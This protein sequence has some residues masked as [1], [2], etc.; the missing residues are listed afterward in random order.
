MS[1]KQQFVQKQAL[2]LKQQLSPK[3]IQQFRLYHLPY[4]EL[5][6]DIKKEAE[7]NV[8]MDITRD[9]QLTPIKGSPRTSD[10]L[11]DVSDFAQDNTQSSL[12]DFLFKQA[13]LVD[14][15]DDTKK[16]LDSLIEAI[17]DSGYIQ[18][19]PSIK[20]RIQ[21]QHSVSSYTVN[22][23]LT[24]LQEFEPEGVGARTLEECLLLQLTQFELENAALEEKIAAVISQ[25]LN[26]LATKDYEHIAK[27]EG[28]P[29]EG[30]TAIESFIKENLNP[31]PG[32]RFSND[33]YNQH[34]SPSF[35]ISLQDGELS[36]KNLEAQL[37]IDFQISAQYLA[38]LNDDTT[39][40]D[41]K[42]FLKQKLEKAKDYKAF[43][44]QRQEKLDALIQFIATKQQLFFEK[45]YD[46]LKPLLQKE[47]SEHIDMP[48]STVSRL[49][50]SKYCRSDQGVTPLKL[51]CP[52]NFY[53][54]TKVQFLHYIEQILKQHPSLSDQKIANLL[55]K[56]GLHIARRTVAKYRQELGLA[57]SY[58][59]GRAEALDK[60]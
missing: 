34:I 7:D 13:R 1:L 3:L 31:K 8:F 33:T 27:Q 22:T 52:R 53:G 42:A 32:A 45:G 43:L 4:H 47:V 29:I 57:S 37:G 49:L 23:A 25:H 6:S 55:K 50:S 24:L 15:K 44:T 9:N 28:I 36:I 26:A 48:P 18:S 10:L 12:Q 59:S 5:V 19:Y 46:Y 58:F 20:K 17:D 14:C 51:L 38:L 60:D 11:R 2:H 41:T 30:V 56:D 35:E 39:D 54:K 40:A 21:A 16:A